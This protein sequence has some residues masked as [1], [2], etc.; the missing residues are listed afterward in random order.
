MVWLSKGHQQWHVHFA[1]YVLWLKLIL[2]ST[3]GNSLDSRR[4]IDHMLPKYGYEWL[5]ISL[6][7]EAFTIEKVVEL[8]HAPYSCHCLTFQ[9]LVVLLSRSQGSRGVIHW[10]IFLKKNCTKALLACIGLQYSYPCICWSKA[11]LW[12]SWTQFFSPANAAS[13]LLCDIVVC[14]LEDE[15]S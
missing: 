1:R 3:N 13:M 14:V 9:I 10:M 4:D 5:L 8:L 11:G 7:G 12:S 6:K 2:P 15:T